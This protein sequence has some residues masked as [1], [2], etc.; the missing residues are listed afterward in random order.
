MRILN[1]QR[2]STED[3][4]G[5]RTTVFLK[6]CPLACA[7]CHNPESLT[8]KIQ[9]EWVQANCIFC[10]QCVDNCKQ[11]ALSLVNKEIIT[12]SMLCTMCLECT[13]ICPAKAMKKIGE[14]IS[15]EQLCKELIKD[16]AYFNTQG[17][18]TLSGG[19][20]L[21]Q[22]DEVLK[23]CI[24]LKENG[25][26]IALDTS[27][28]AAFKNF[29]TLLPY[30][31]LILYDLKILNEHRHKSLCKTGNKL[32][33]E[34]LVKLSARNVSLWIRTPII[35]SA[36][37]DEDNIREIAAFLQ[38]EAINFERWELCA[39]NNLCVS[40]Y[41]RLG[42]DWEYSHADLVS[43]DKLNQLLEAAKAIIPDKP[44]MVTGLALLEGLPN[45]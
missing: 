27:G 16:K 20:V 11:K 36:T 26:K 31:D 17:G 45:V 19:E 6:G 34:N 7:W 5:I 43:K 15:A 29:E 35:P 9:K 21:M 32:I 28:F 37:D 30:V 10:L 40:K 39:F 12:D 1:I 3:G 25:I 18:I 33:L 2:M 23:L 13:D 22:T 41:E 44:I 4:P 38:E 8:T 14:D 42:F 24:L